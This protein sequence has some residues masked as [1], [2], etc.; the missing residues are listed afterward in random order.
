MTSR[1]MLALLSA[2]LLVFSPAPSAA[3]RP[4]AEA[5]AEAA[6]AIYRSAAFKQAWT[7]FTVPEDGVMGTCAVEDAT[8]FG[9]IV[10]GDLVC[11]SLAVHIELCAWL[12][13]P[14]EIAGRTVTNGHQFVKKSLWPQVCAPPISSSPVCARHT[15]RKFPRTPH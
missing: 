10:V 7:Q 14:F 1:I 13:M 3:V 2:G 11:P 6:D 12:K 8:S 5:I 4:P 15:C 9:A